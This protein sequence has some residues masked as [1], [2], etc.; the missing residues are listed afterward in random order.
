M[1]VTVFLRHLQTW[2]GNKEP[3]SYGWEISINQ[4]SS[5]AKVLDFH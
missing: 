2:S 4:H 1:G 5:I 3:T